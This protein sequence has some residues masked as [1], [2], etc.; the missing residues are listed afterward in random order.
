M[1]ALDEILSAGDLVAVLGRD[2][3]VRLVDISASGCLLEAGNRLPVGA[4][5]SLRV[6]FE[7][8]DYVD[9]IRIMRCRECDGSSSWYHLGA[10][11]L[12]TNAPHEHSLRRLVGRLQA[13]AIKTGWFK[14]SNT[15]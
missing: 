8:N 10:E 14:Q 3:S 7:E 12:W 6:I 1:D 4:T 15:M 11:F 2:V 13:S 5:G 9:D